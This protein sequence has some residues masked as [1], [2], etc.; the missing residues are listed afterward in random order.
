MKKIYF[1]L[2]SIILSSVIAAAPITTDGLIAFYD[3]D[4]NTANDQSGNGG[5][6]G[7]LN[8]VSI[9]PNGAFNQ[10]FSFDG[11]SSI[12]LGNNSIIGS[13]TSFSI[14]AWVNANSFGAQTAIYGEFNTNN[15]DTRNYLFLDSSGRV[16]FDQFPNSGGALVSQNSIATG[17]FSQIVYTQDGTTRRIYIDGVLEAEDTSIETYQGSVPDVARIGFR[18]NQNFG[19][20]GVLDEIAFYDR[21]LSIEQVTS[22]FAAVPEPSTYIAFLFGLFAIGYFRKRK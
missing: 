20:D 10:G 12:D 17:Q 18:D 2:I 19:F 14:V 7:T 16:F 13:D 4:D 11:N 1:I 21:A 15:I 5:P 22:Q 3:A 9:S 6:N 8:G